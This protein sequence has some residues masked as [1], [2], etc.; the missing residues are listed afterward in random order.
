M[1]EVQLGRIKGDLAV[2]QRAMGL[3]PF[4]GKG[5]LVF[6]F[7]LAVAAIG[8]AVVSLLVESDWL[9]LTPLAAIMVAGPVG[10]YLRSRRSNDLSPEIT[11][12]VLLSVA[13]YGI[14]WGAAC[15]YAMANFLG[16]SVGTARTAVFY[17]VSIGLLLA[18]SLILVHMALKSRERY[19]CLGLA[20]S[21]LFSG[22]L[23]P[24]FDRHYSY[25]LAHCFM[26]LGYLTGVAIQSAQLR[27]AVVN[28]AAD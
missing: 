12:Q 20:V 28:H 3:Q 16:P 9:Q 4:F 27:R 19:Y 7:L 1:L 26:A 2:I 25:F 10:L 6:G 15:G 21:T 18:N 5:M 8:A 11:V 24:V 13:I 14:V 17:A 23:L 22:M